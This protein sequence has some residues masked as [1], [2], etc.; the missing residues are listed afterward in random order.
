MVSGV[1]RPLALGVVRDGERVFVS[2]GYDPARG[3]TFYRP[4]GGGITFGERSQDAVVREFRE[5]LHAELANVTFLATIEHVFTYNGERGHEIALVY[6]GDFVDETLYERQTVVGS[7][8]DGTT[9][10][11]VWRRLSDFSGA[12]PLYPD[13]LLELLR[14]DGEA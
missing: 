8:D 7:E 13:G 2:E 3:L 4:F 9:L 14:D 11:G 6:E 12:T 10:I 1:V 5:E